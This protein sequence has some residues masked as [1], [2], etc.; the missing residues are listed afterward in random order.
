MAMM[1]LRRS[2]G[3]EANTRKEGVLEK[4]GGGTSLFGSKSFKRRYVTIE[5]GKLTYF[6]VRARRPFGRHTL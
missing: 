4:Q 3:G 2:A 6:A 1:A 5:D